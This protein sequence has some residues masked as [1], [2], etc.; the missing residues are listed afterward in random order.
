MVS[1]FGSF[2]IEKTKVVDYRQCRGTH[3]WR[4]EKFIQVA[5]ERVCP[6][7]RGARLW[8]GE[9]IFLCVE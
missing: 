3:M 9:R 4:W 7:T 5:L 2:L 8:C 6:G 1:S